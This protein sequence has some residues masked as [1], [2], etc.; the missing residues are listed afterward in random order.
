[1]KLGRADHG[2][3]LVEMLAVLS[4]IAIAAA[5]SLPMVNRGDDHAKLRAVA[6]EL[7]GALRQQRLAALYGNEPAELRF[8]LSTGLITAANG[9]KMA[10]LP[11]GVSATIETAQQQISKGKAA[12]GFFADGGS[13]GGA[14]TLKSGS[15]AIAIKINWLTGAAVTEEATKP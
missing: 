11:P 4:L 5:L 13:T 14:I 12:I 7:S 6:A 10:Q 9:K 2:F 8:D 3:S 1:M 15:A